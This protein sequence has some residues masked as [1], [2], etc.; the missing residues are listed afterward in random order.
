MHEFHAWGQDDDVL[1]SLERE[2]GAQGG[3]YQSLISGSAT[4]FLLDYGQVA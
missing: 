2:Y 3:T 1:H 4:P